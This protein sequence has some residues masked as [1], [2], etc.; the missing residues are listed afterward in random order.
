MTLTIRLALRD[1][2]YLTPLLLG[3][4]A[5]RRIELTIDRVG[6][7]VEDLAG[8]PAHDAA[9]I[10]L[11]RHVQ[12]VAGGAPGVVGV[13]CFLMRG[14][15]HRCILTTRS[16][17]RRLGDLA[18]ARIG[19]TGWQD[20][21]NTW[22]RAVLA[23]EG[24]GVE[25]AAWFAGRLTEAH[26]VVDRLGRFARPGRI[27]AMPGEEPMMQALEAGRL[28]AVFTPF[29]PE[30]FFRR[31][32]PFRPV[33]EDFRSAEIGYF[34]RNGYVPGMHILALKREVATAH[35][36]LAAA[37]TRLFDRSLAMWLAKRR[38]Y[39]ET[40]PWILQ[41]IATMDLELG[42]DWA[43]SGIKANAPMVAD[44]LGHAE[45]Q[46]L[47]PRRPTLAEIFPSDAP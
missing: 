5:D 28:D 47:L 40:T 25:D 21:G 24:V 39:A 17:P 35:P 37:L 14:F 11:S 44:F 32:S 27:E 18:G 43:A 36:W 16:G 34:R 29:M 7:L 1:W 41:D 6:T 3:D 31:D 12:A 13:P 4:V 33:L 38:K 8:D 15:R 23:E 22:T 46:G 9:E 45:T 42:E 10:S 2:D 19:V 30:G 20:S 26:P